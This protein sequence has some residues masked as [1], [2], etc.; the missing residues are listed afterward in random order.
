MATHITPQAMEFLRED[1]DS[2][3]E[4]S[5]FSHGVLMIAPFLH[6]MDEPLQVSFL[7][8]YR[9][10]S[11]D[12]SGKGKKVDSLLLARKIVGRKVFRC[13][14]SS[15]GNTI[16]AFFTGLCSPHPSVEISVCRYR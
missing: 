15:P 13:Y 5:D 14:I 16:I 3:G 1:N 4:K 2:F 9:R 12:K 11:C 6:E 10:L 8:E 7:A